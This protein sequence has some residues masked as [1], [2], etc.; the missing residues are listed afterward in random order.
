MRTLRYSSQRRRPWP[1]WPTR[2]TSTPSGSRW[3]AS[4]AHASGRA[5]PGSAPSRTSPRQRGT[6]RAA[7]RW[8]SRSTPPWRAA[9]R[10]RTGACAARPWTP[11]PSAPRQI[12]PRPWPLRAGC[13]RTRWARSG[14]QPSRPSRRWCRGAAGRPSTGSPPGST[15]GTSP[16]AGRPSSPS[17][18]SRRRATS[19]RS[20][21]RSPPATIGPGLSER[22]QRTR[23]PRLP[24]R[25]TSPHS[26]SSQ[27]CLRTSTP[28]PAWPPST[29]SRSSAAWAT[30][31][32]SASQRRDWSTVTLARGRPASSFLRR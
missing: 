1:R 17:R 21:W 2:A 10:T 5:S 31:R 32:P 18:R 7:R 8:T 6:P 24:P 11:W 14:S 30:A 20:S 9:L 29:A 4:A 28:C 15:T 19:M 22:L 16:C 3:S 12:A 25:T 26:G 27:G 23:W 13:W